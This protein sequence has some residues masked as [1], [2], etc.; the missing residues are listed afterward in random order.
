MYNSLV[1]YIYQ[2]L[3]RHKSQVTLHYVQDKKKQPQQK[4]QQNKQTKNN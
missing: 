1:I 2:Y 3:S 4:Q